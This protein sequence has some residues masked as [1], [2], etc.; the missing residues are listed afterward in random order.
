MTALDIAMLIALSAIWGASY[1]FIRVAGP[2]FGPFAL[3]D[4][5]VWLA[6]SA[7]VPVAL[8]ARQLPDLRARWR[9]YLL[10]GAI[11]AAIPFTLITI[12]VGNLNA[13][14]SSILNAT[15]PL[16][17]AIAAAIWLKER[18]TP[19][20]IVGMAL[21]L[22]GV[23]A[24]VGL[25]PL[26]MTPV[27][28]LS[29]GGSLLS[30]MCYG[31]GGVVARKRFAG[32]P[33]LALTIGQQ[34]A[35]GAILL[36]LA[37]LAPP[38]RMATGGEVGALLALALICTSLAYLIYFRLVARVGPARTLLGTFLIP[39]FSLLWGV[40]FLGEPVNA[41]V[42]LGLIL[43]LAGMALATGLVGARRAVKAS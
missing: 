21:G 3:I 27:R 22:A 12:S 4:V 19:L 7:L 40:I 25:N 30:A 18:L 34:L 1:L 38:P 2:A 24:L 8:A 37:L 28:L 10:L 33:S 41:G 26:E 20:K 35:A 43:I 11:N 31:A 39:F 14:I 15:T 23:V 17:A 42:G 32:T 13:S 9:D 6:G 29:V 36:P 16:C 5:R